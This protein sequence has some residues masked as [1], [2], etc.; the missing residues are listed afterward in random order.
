MIQTYAYTHTLVSILIGKLMR[1]LIL[2][3]RVVQLLVSAAADIQLSSRDQ[4]RHTALHF[5]G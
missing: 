5:A 3:R 1:V 2:D 4:Y